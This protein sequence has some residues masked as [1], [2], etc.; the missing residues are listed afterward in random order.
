MS[1]RETCRMFGDRL[2]PLTHD[3][4][5]VDGARLLWAIAGVESSYGAQREFARIEPAYQPGGSMYRGSENVRA[6]W[7]RYGALAA[8][9]YGTWQMM[10]A[11]AAEL[12]FSGHPWELQA[13]EMLAP[14][15]AAYLWRSKART[16][17]EAL[18]A[19][20]SGSCRD[21]LIPEAYVRSGLAAYLRG[22]DGGPQ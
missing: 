22:W 15:V 5:P 2:P 3:E 13:D 12:G 18:D 19:Y 17:R 21:R 6:L 14:L 9:S 10:A 7:H 1:L 11:T 20:N 8:C 16:L 4:Q